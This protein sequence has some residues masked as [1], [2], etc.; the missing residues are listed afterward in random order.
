MRRIALIPVYNEESTL[1]AVL[2]SVSPR[3]HLLVV[4]DD[5]SGDSS[6][7]LAMAYARAHRNVEVLRLEKNRGMSAAL[8]EGFTHLAARVREGVLA[9]EDV[10]LTLDADGQHD[11]SEI[12]ALC[13]HLEEAGLDVALTCRDFVLY[14]AYKRLGNLLMTLWG[15]LWSGHHYDDVESGF[16]AMRLK[17]LQPMLDYYT[18]YRYSCAQEIAILTARLGFCVDNRFVT[19]IRRYRSQ[20]GVRDVVVN[21]GLGFWAFVRWALSYRVAERPAMARRVAPLEP[22]DGRPF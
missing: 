20:T 1:L 8:R 5:G 3:V 17:V 9:P 4:V 11:S 18:G 19:A 10:L 13:L 22:A 7:R 21:A 15:S 12:E 14:P 2:E 6:L 16:R